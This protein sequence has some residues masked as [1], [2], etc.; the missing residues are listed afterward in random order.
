MGHDRKTAGAP[1][2]I[3]RRRT[4]AILAAAGATLP[5]TGAS[6]MRPMPAFEWRGRAL[7][8]PARIVIRHPDEAK[9]RRLVDH[10][11]RE[12]E[13]L[14]NIF[15]LYRA[16]SEIARLNR[17]GRLAAPSQ[18]LRLVLADARR[19]ATLSGG[20]FDVT[21]QPLWRLYSGHFGREQG[22]SVV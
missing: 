10:C 3:T 21:V 6:S 17:E 12:I 13:R 20:A 9:A 14:E 2:R 15:S 18:D 5:L 16:Q 22:K 1:R 4:L 19:Y 7:G 8:G 11:A